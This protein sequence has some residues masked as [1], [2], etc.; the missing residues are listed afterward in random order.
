M[1][2]VEGGILKIPFLVVSNGTGQ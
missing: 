1:P 2:T